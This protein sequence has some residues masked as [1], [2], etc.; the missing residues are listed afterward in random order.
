MNERNI[1]QEKVRVFFLETLN[2]AARSSSSDLLE[3]G[4]LD[5]LALVDLLLYLEQEFGIECFSSH[6][7]ID[8]FRSIA[9]IT[10]YVMMQIEWHA[11]VRLR[12]VLT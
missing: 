7:R 2:R 10:E 6:L 11:P 1:I 12:E 4:L 5:S 8:D 3:E 9:A